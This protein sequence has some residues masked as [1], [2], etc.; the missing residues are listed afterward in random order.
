MNDIRAKFEEIWP[1]PEGIEW[2][3]DGYYPI[4]GGRITVEIIEK[5]LRFD[6]RLD[7]FTRCHESMGPVMSLV[8]ELIKNLSE[9]ANKLEWLRDARHYEDIA[10][11]AKQIIGREK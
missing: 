3:I 7:T 11:R 1:V 9:C 10:N 2:R 4:S 5:C 8:D 6:D